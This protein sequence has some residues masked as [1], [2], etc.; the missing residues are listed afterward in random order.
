MIIFIQND[1]EV[2]AGIYAEYLAEQRIPFTVIKSYCDGAMP[3][4]D[5]ISA[6]IVL[7]GSMG[8]HDTE[9]H[10]FLLQVKEYIGNIIDSGKPYLGICLGGQ[11]LADVLSADVS[12]VL[13]REIGT[14]QVALTR[15]GLSDPLFRSVPEKFFTFQWHND[16]FAIP[17]GA[18]RMAYSDECPNQAFRHGQKAYGLQF[19]PEVN[20]KI[21]KKWCEGFESWDA[22]PSQI[23]SAFESGEYTYRTVSL[24]IL[25]NFIDIAR[26]SG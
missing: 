21:V 15:D 14:C 13:H 24:R 8:V 1:P 7:G 10:P 25:E 2:P 20:R 16:S 12:S 22:S 6:V 17:S 9:R 18:V 5:D 26:Y 19:H 23:I 3:G 11:L 4:I